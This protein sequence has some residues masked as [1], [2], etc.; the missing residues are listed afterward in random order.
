M[1]TS[2][3]ICLKP[4]KDVQNLFE[5]QPSV[6]LQRTG[7]AEQQARFVRFVHHAVGAQVHDHRIFAG[8]ARRH[9]GQSFFQMVQ[10]GPGRHRTAKVVRQH[11]EIAVRQIG[12]LEPLQILGG[13]AVR[14]PRRVVLPDGQRDHRRLFRDVQHRDH[15]RHDQ[16][17]RA[18]R[19][20]DHPQTMIERCGL[21][22][23][24]APVLPF[25]RTLASHGLAARGRSSALFS[26]IGT[27]RSVHADTL[28]RGR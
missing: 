22:G 20:R 26:P 2:G 1:A 14:R 8:T 15:K 24:H 27:I 7:V 12:L 3:G 17:E 6:A 21:H 16:A 10:C 23:V 19:Q 5:R 13:I 18:E 11:L 9:A 28:A 25:A 4:P